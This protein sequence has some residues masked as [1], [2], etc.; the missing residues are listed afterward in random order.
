MFLSTSDYI[1]IQPTFTS[2]R[3]QLSRLFSFYFIIIFK[4]GKWW[5]ENKKDSTGLYSIFFANLPTAFAELLEYPVPAITTGWPQ[6]TIAFP[7]KRFWPYSC[8][9]QLLWLRQRHMKYLPPPSAHAVA[10]PD[11]HQENP[12]SDAQTWSKLPCQKSQSIPSNGT[13]YE[14]RRW[15]WQ[16]AQTLIQT[17]AR[18]SSKSSAKPD[19]GN[20]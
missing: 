15:G 18:S 20:L 9:L 13:S 14:N 16:S 10:C 12:A 17:Q 19:Y 1:I 4:K 6:K 8:N 2:E 7:K 5:F 3:S 11:E